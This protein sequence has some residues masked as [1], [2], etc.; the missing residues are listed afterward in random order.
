MKAIF[1][2]ILICSSAFVFSQT[3]FNLYSVKARDSE[4]NK[5][6]EGSMYFDKDFHLAIV[7]GKKERPYMLR[8]NAYLDVMEFY[9]GKEL[10]FVGKDQH[11]TF[12]FGSGNKVYILENYV[13]K[14]KNESISGYLIQ[15]V[16]GNVTLYKSQNIAHKLADTRNIGFGQESKPE[17]LE[18]TK[19]IFYIKVGEANVIELPGS[20]DK[21]AQ[22]LNRNKKELSK[23]MKENSLNMKAEKDIVQLFKFVNQ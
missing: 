23:F 1:S 20:I 8:Y 22:L 7:D 18:A 17:R 2:F 9:E 14:G 16:K 10:F 6:V 19:E 21:L 15:L 11:K 4:F 13:P 3:T 5:E 12:D